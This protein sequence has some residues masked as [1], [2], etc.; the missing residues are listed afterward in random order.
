MYVRLIDIVLIVLFGF[1]SIST[2][3]S[4][5]KIPL[6][7]SEEVKI[8]LPDT[9]LVVNLTLGNDDDI[10]IDTETISVTL[11]DAKLYL[12]DQMDRL[13]DKVKVKIRAPRYCPFGSVRKVVYMCDELEVPRSVM[14]EVVGKDKEK[15]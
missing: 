13:G 14:V 8:S 1:I 7:K 5:R 2:L 3:D 6:P 4:Q 12:Q 10:Y 11:S 9:L 15:L